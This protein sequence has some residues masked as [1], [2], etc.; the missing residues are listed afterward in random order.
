MNSQLMGFLCQI[1]ISH[2][3]PITGPT[4]IAITHCGVIAITIK[5]LLNLRPR[6]FTGAVK[7]SISKVAFELSIY[8]FFVAHLGRCFIK[9]LKGLCGLLLYRV[10]VEIFSR[11]GHDLD[12][13]QI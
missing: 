10:R 2:I 12:H 4:Q 6:W 11:F 3:W 1:L 13:R 8:L 9:L 5:I 7:L